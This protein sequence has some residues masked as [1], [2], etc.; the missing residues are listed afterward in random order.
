MKSIYLGCAILLIAA[1]AW[2]RRHP[3][4]KVTS[5]ETQVWWVALI[6]IRATFLIVAVILLVEAEKIV[7]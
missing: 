1:I 2:E 4:I 5:T 3:V 7:E 6:C